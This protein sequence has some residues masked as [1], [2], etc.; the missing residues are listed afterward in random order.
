MFDPAGPAGVLLLRLTVAALVF[1]LAVRPRVRGWPPAAWRAAVLL[2]VCSAG[3]NGLSYVALDVAPQGVVVTASFAGPLV[4]A[5]VQTRRPVDLAWAVTAGAGVALLGLRTGVDVPVAGLLAAL[6]AGGCGAGYIWCS[7]RLG[8]VLPGF[9]GLAVSFMVAAALV[10]P[11]GA[12]GAGR[13]LRDPLLLAGA[14]VVAV[15]SSVVPYAMELI[16][17]RRMSTRVFGILMSLQPAAAALAGLLLLGQ[18]LGTLPI[19]ALILV[20]AAAAGATTRPAAAVR[21]R[22]AR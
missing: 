11:F 8:G 14:V 5:L 15:L 3:L 21:A 1:G 2:G 12:A 4:L 9:G 6:A 13:A 16:A 10:L 17:L 20:T 22:A 7:A 18:R 19:A